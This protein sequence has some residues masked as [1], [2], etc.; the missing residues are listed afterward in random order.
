MAWHPIRAIRNPRNRPLVV[1]WTLVGLVVFAT[2]WMVGLNGTSSKWFCTRPCHIVH[3]DNTLAYDA[4]SHTEVACVACHE[5]VNA[6]VHEFT[7][8]KIEVAPDAID[9]IR[10][11]FE[12]PMNADNHIAIQMGDDFCTQCHD[13]GNR[14][15]TPAKGIL[16]DHDAHTEKQ[17]TCTTCH[18]RVAHPEEDITLVLENDRK[19]DNWMTMDAC[20]RCHGLERDSDA[21]GACTACHPTDFELVPASHEATGW[22]SAKGD[23]SGH[24]EAAKE[25]S[26][27]VA[28]AE[29]LFKEARAEYPEVEEKAAGP[30]LGPSS[31]V[32]SCYTC[33]QPSFCTA[34]HGMPIP[35]PAEFKKSHAETGYKQPAPCKRC[36]A[37]AAKTNSAS[38]NACH[39][40][41]PTPD[42]PFVST[43]FTVVKSDGAEPCYACHEVF[44]CE[45]CHVQGKPSTRY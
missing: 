37:P 39:H 11:T 4:S 1:I 13:L 35:H 26:A 20:F 24:A 9:T 16:I 42:A 10:Q 38:C 3:D 25:E 40:K 12:L 8:L 23:S 44:F 22:Y 41:T 36:H 6:G 28:E 29:E 18:N 30:I 19:H 45:S 27:S 7:L 15:I 31:G 5:P 14:K 34:C 32:N 17:V 33:H 43:H 21:P 2:V